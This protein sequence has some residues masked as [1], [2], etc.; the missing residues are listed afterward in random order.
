[1]TTSLAPQK[2]KRSE[3]AVRPKNDLSGGLRRW[4]PDEYHRLKQSGFFGEE[5]TELLN[6]F[7]W[8]PEASDI[9]RWSREEYYRLGEM[10]FFDE[11]RVELLDGR[12]WKLP[13]QKTPH[14]TAVRRTTETLEEVFGADYEVRPQGPFSLPDGSEPEPD[15]LVVPGTMEDY[16][17]HHPIVSDCL[18]L[19]EISDS[20]L[21][22]DRGTKLIDYARAG[23]TDYWIVNLVHK[24][25]EIYRQPTPEG[26]YLDFHR[27]SPGESVEPLNAP[28]KPV[29]VTD[30]LPP[31]PKQKL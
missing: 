4:T 12:I 3:T 26:I 25:L 13:P 16:T 15:I 29:A 31:E 11:E 5:R 21:A 18:L 6:G 9:R 10:G 28:G 20:T 8:H 17:E 27:Y 1:M 19:V 7:I 2:T 24:R 22:K 23:I 30:L 14:F